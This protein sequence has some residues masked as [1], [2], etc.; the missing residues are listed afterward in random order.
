MTH[1]DVDCPGGIAHQETNLAR[2]TMSFSD[3]HNRH[4]VPDKLPHLLQLE[5]AP[6]L[7]L[8]CG[9][10]PRPDGPVAATAQEQAARPAARDGRLRRPQRLNPAVVGGH[11]GAALASHS[12]IDR[13]RPVGVA[14]SAQALSQ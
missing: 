9:R 4:P 3:R 7:S 6:R 2:G 8:S 10:P 1:E 5:A 13:Y 12:F 11:E 14:N